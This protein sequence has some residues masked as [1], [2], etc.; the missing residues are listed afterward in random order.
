VVS[1]ALSRTLR[2]LEQVRV[3]APAAPQLLT[4]D[5]VSQYPGSFSP[6]GT[7]FV[8]V[9]ASGTRQ[10][11]SITIQERDGKLEAG[12]AEP[13]AP[14][15]FNE[16]L[17]AVSPDGRWL[18]YGSDESKRREIYVRPFPG[19][20]SG[21]NSRWPISNGGGVEAR[22]S[23]D[24]QRIVYRAG[25]QLMSVAYTVKGD[26]FV[27]DAPKV[28]IERLGAVEEVVWGAV[29][30]LAPDGERVIVVTPM[31]SAEAPQPEHHVVILQNFF[32]E[33]RRRAPLPE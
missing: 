2:G 7:R 27:A 4:R 25:D 13:V 21:P 6:D 22:W 15:R 16:W 32:D 19:S 17:P 9:D 26:A 33:L 14:A 1:L 31:E 23:R 5:N 10:I 3:D 30:D 12:P 20:S 8:Y 11:R 24:G 29:W 28:W 18:A